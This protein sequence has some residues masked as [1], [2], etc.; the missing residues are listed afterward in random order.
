MPKLDILLTPRDPILVRDGRPFTAEAGAGAC[1]LPWPYPGTIAGALRTHYGRLAG[2]NWYADGPQRVLDG[3][4]LSGPL[5]AARSDE[6]APWL[7][8][9]P[10]PAD[11]LLLDGEKGNQVVRLAPLQEYTTG[12]GCDLPFGLRPLLTSR[13][14]KPVGGQAYWSLADTASWL[15]GA[16]PTRITDALAAMPRDT[17][18]HVKVD[19][20]TYCS[21]E[22]ML[23]SVA[24]LS[25]NDVAGAASPA[26]AMLVRVTGEM[27]PKS[28]EPA[29]LPVG[30]ER[31]VAHLSAANWP[32]MP[33]ALEA[34][35]QSVR[36]T[37][38]L[39]LQLATPAIFSAGWRPGWLH[40]ESGRLQGEI[41]QLPGVTLRLISAGVGTR[42]AVSGWNMIRTAEGKK[43]RGPKAARYLAPAG[44]VY[45]F[46]IISGSLEADGWRKLWLRSLCDATADQHDGYGLALPGVWHYQNA[47]EVY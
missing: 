14:G 2:V 10:T 21:E 22:G 13:K 42:Q 11:A 25:L 18:T 19:P 24:Y 28:A 36:D 7:P 9:F 47:N 34:A 3:I 4:H 45:F 16:T 15:G 26:I 5:L 17:R 41:P 29:W 8:Y 40:E 20:A 30:G 6:N 44:S 23:F 32:E 27:A 1:S 46:E 39:R 35:L 12:S 31:R 37:R 43:E 33:A 38:R